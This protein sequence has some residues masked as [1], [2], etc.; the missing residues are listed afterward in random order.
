MRRLGL[1]QLSGPEKEKSIFSQFYL[2]CGK[3]CKK[4]DWG[5]TL[6]KMFEIEDRT[7]GPVRF[8]YAIK[9]SA[10]K[11]A[12]KSAVS[13]GKRILEYARDRYRDD[14]ESMPF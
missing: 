5:D 13:T 7:L 14:L 12:G 11:L 2:T 1:V 4:T 9:Y 10:I 8:P 3:G 6:R